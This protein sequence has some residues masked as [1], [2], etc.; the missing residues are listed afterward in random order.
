MENEILNEERLTANIDN[1]RTKINDFND[2]TYDYCRELK[3]TSYESR[4]AMLHCQSINVISYIVSL[5]YTNEEFENFINTLKNI[6]YLAK[7]SETKE[8]QK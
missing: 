3:L 8:E 2:K 7:Q 6:F 1:I 5:D 4:F